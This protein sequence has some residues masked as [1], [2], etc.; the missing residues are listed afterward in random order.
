MTFETL[1][2]SCYSLFL[3]ILV[4][5]GTHGYSMVWLYRRKCRMPDPPPPSL[6]NPLP[7]VTIQIPLYN[8]RYVARRII[9]ACAAF[10]YPRDRF[11]IQ[12][13][14]D[15][16]DD[17]LI[18]TRSLVAQLQAQ[19]IRISHHHRK[20]RTGY[21]SGAL[22]EG[23]AA[24]EG[25]FIAIFDADFA[26]AEDFLHTTLPYFANDRIGMVQTRWGH[27]NDQYSA[28]TRLQAIALD[29]HLV[30]E[31]TARNRSGLFMNFNGTAGVW[32]K[33][34]ILD[35]GNWEDDTLTEDMDLSYRAQMR[36]WEFLF[37]RDSISPAELPTEMNALKSQ[38]FRWTKGNVETARKILPRLWRAP[39]S[40]KQR[41]AGTSHLLSWLSNPCILGVAL[42]N[43]PLTL[44]H[45][46][47]FGIYPLALLLIAFGL[48]FFGALA[49]HMQAQQAT[50][51]DWRRRM[52]WFPL[53]MSGGM[54]LSIN[55]TIAVIEGLLGKKT[56]FI[57]TPKYHITEETDNWAGKEYMS[58]PNMVILL[59]AA[60]ALYCMTGLVLA[61]GKGHWAALPFHLLFTKG[62]FT[63]FWYSLQ[64]HRAS[65][66][67]LLPHTAEA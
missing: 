40:L 9:H 16:T 63:L 44:L 14:D 10:D 52:L 61:A 17:T 35:A 1:L 22:R 24:A 48:G 6:P 21:K 59:E 12:V 42:L 62:F 33:A 19:G 5:S 11:D 3:F 15:S 27:L 55:N 30:I 2:L 60:M 47:R 20:D 53:F 58:R 23:L 41:L 13:L 57:R 8:E 31:Q 39:V 51:P 43:P 65:R 49:L 46:Q 28:L 45:W 67:A 50:Y 36:G 56:P 29:G 37:L 34:T 32:R 64:H 54:G 38:Q 25:E 26:P 66:K 7:T 4:L 18:I